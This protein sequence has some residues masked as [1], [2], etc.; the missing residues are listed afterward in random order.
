LA[1]LKIREKI[2][3]LLVFYFL[4][5]MTAI[6]FTLFVSWQL[7]GGAA[8]INDAGKE[9][10]RTYRIAFLLTQHAQ[11]ATPL[12]ENDIRQ[13]VRRFDGCRLAGDYFA[14]LHILATAGAAGAASEPGFA[15]YGQGRF[16]RALADCQKRR[17]GRTG[18]RF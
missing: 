16:Q 14:R 12:L 10:M 4:I 15:K 7:E 13:E 3:G 8:A 17:V 6:G 2:T 18:A 11:Q 9:R 5:A 1:K